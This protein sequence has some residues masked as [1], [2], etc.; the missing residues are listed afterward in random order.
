MK[1]NQDNQS[2][3]GNDSRGTKKKEKETG[4]S[5][6]RERLF[7]TLLSDAPS[8]DQLFGNHIVFEGEF[9]L[10]FFIVLQSEACFIL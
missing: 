3:A 1:T 4:N 7:I 8:A 9:I 5:I 6:E 10:H 2:A